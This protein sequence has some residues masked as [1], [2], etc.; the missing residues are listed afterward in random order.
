[1]AEDS[2]LSGICGFGGPPFGGANEG[3]VA[4]REQINALH[5][6]PLKHRPG[7]EIPGNRTDSHLVALAEFALVLTAD[8]RGSHWNKAPKGAGR[9]IRRKEFFPVIQQY[10]SLLAALRHFV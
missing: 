8:Q 6:I 5:S 1:M 4:S 2:K 3:Y 10:G 7:K 9:L